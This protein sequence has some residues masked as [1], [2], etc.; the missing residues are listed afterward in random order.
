MKK[1][2]IYLLSTAIIIPALVSCSDFLDQ[3]PDL[4][5]TLDSEE[6]IANILVSAYVSGSGSYQLVAELS[7]DNVCDRGVTKDYN[8]FYQDVYEWAEDVTSNNDAPRNIWSA[9]YSNIANANQA[10]SAIE[11]MGGPITASLKASKG[12]ALL[13][14]AYSH[15]V[16]ANM[17]CMPYNAE[18]AENYLGI[19]YMDHAETDL[20]P[21][22]ERGTLKEVYEKIGRDI[23]EGI[24]LIDDT[25]YSVPKYHFNYKA[26]CCFASRYYL[27]IH[28]WDNAIKYATMALTSNPESLLRDYDAIAALPNSASRHQEYV[29]SSSKANFLLQAATSS[30]GLVFGWYTTAGRYAHGKLQGTYETVQPKEG[31]PWGSGVSFKA[32]HA[33]LGSSGKYIL[34]RTWRVFQYTDPVAGTGYNKAVSV[35]FSTEEALLNRAEA[36]IMKMSEDPSNADLALADMNLYA[37]NLF[38]SGFT[39]MTLE[40]IKEWAT[41]TYKDYSELYVGTTSTTSPQT[42]NPKKKLFA[43]PYNA[44]EEKQESMLQALIFMRRYQFLHEG[45]RWFDTRRFGITVYRYLL[46]EDDETILQIT[47]K[48][49]D[50]N[51]TPDPRRALQLPSDVISAGLTPNP[52][53]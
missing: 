10:L 22:Y 38:S 36:Y 52:R 26:A 12:E 39:P 44:L 4:R 6:K 1:S 41:V 50:E 49:S 45:M 31:G 53:N 3:N 18:T 20:N 48:I 28:D 47:D 30:S 21:Q 7:S 17:F 24:P 23:E 19:P 9:N 33:V 51:G 35:L 14:R 29:N 27:F 32:G 2:I 46:D 8:Q 11:D 15:F 25:S 37:G 34:P 40:S 13:C 42:L 43:A 16:L 5:T